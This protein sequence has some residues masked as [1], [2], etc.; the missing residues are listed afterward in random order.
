[1]PVRLI[2]QRAQADKKQTNYWMRCTPAIQG[3]CLFSDSRFLT[4]KQRI[5][6]QKGINSMELNI[7]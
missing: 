2:Q 3:S 1:M 4:R 6:R 5:Y 7:S